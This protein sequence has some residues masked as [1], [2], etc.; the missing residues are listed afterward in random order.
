MKYFIYLF[1][2]CFA[3]LRADEYKLGHGLKLND[4]LSI[5]GYFSVDYETGDQKD[6]FRLDDV[7]ILAY[8][9]LSS[10]FSYLTEFEAAPFYVEN[11]TTGTSTTNTEF[12]YER[13]YID[14]IYSEMFNIRLGKQITPIGYWN[15]EPINVLRDTSSNP[16]YSNKMFP[17]LL[18]GIDLYGYLD[19][20]N[21]LKYHIFMQKNKDLDEEYINI[22]N[23]HFFGF[24]LEHEFSSEFSF[25]GALGNY[26]TTIDDKDIKFVQLDAKYDN[27]PFLIQSEL[28]YNDINNKTLDKKNY[29]FAGYTQ[30]VYN[31]N[32]QHALISRY[33]Y[34]DDNEA[35][36]VNHIGVFGY[37]YR[38]LYSIS[39]KT[40]YQWN[41][42]SELSK[43]LISFSVLF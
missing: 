14:Y 37:S 21:V 34:F 1:V 6:Q 7:A 3:F 11:Y 18:T 28:A 25:G 15:L 29:Q 23:E 42:E 33:E 31:F 26:I 24:S 17:K 36:K 22:Q 12:H 20:D 35:D 5:G 9:S 10:N 8:G 13:V 39:V 40:E 27:Y 4:K 19:D 30:S 41:S 43:S 32:M 38:P 16:H 2:F